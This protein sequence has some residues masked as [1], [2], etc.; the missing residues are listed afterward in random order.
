MKVLII[1]DDAETVMALRR[2]LRTYFII[3]AAKTGSEGVHKAEVGDYDAIIL[4]LG[5]PDMTGLEVCRLLYSQPTSSPV[6]VHSE[7]SPLI[8]K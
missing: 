5:L 6:L 8:S 7:H 3:A 1:E 4:D 2:G